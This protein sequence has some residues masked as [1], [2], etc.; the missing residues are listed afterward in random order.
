MIY[1]L[2]RIKNKCMILVVNSKIFSRQREIKKRVLR[3]NKM[4]L[5]RHQVVHNQGDDQIAKTK[6]RSFS[7]NLINL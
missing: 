3:H 6:S 1:Y 5:H 2:T 4:R 7:K